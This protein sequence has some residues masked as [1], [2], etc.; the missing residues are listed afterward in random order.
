MKRILL[1]LLLCSQLVSGQLVKLEQ[2]NYT[3]IF[4]TILCQ[5]VYSVYELNFGLYSKKFS[6]GT[7]KSNPKIKRKKQGQL[8]DYSC[9]TLFDRG[10]LVPILDFEFSKKDIKEID[11]YTN[12][13]PQYFEVNRGVWRDLENYINYLH[14]REY[15]K[16]RVWVGCDY[17]FRKIG[18]LKIPLNCW[19]LICI[20]NVY[21][22]WVVPNSRVDFA[23]FS[24]YKCDPL[25]LIEK[26]NSFGFEKIIVK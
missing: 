19:K 12:V 6:R 15:K 16:V 14:R 1:L 18:K 21:F 11:Y 23:S 5:P 10:H 9:D 22:G 2:S 7:L 13:V 8:I 3:T 17:G 24:Y 25:I 26:V 20:D 4:D